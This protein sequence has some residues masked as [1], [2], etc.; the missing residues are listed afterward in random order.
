MYVMRVSSGLTTVIRPRVR[1]RM[2]GLNF[3][4]VTFPDR[5]S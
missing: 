3:K 4:L 1:D 2:R 5:L